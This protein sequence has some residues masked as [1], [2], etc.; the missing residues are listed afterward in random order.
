MTEN[1]TL[2][3]TLPFFFILL[4]LIYSCSDS[5]KRDKS[6]VT[7]HKD[8]IL[9]TQTEDSYSNGHLHGSSLKTNIKQQ[10]EVW[11]NHMFS[12]LDL[13]P[14]NMIDIV[15]N[16]TNFF[17]IIK[18]ST[19][20]LLKEINGIA[21]GSGLD[22]KLV[23]CYNLGEEIYNYRNRPIEQCS[24]LAIEEN[25]KKTLL[26][27]QDL[28]LFL[29][30]NNVP[31]I[32]KSKETIVFTLA[33]MLALSGVSK[34]IAVSCNSL[35]M[36]T[37]NKNGLP[38]SF[39]IREILSQPSSS[40]AFAYIQKTP[41]AIPQNF[42][43]ISSDE[44]VGYEISKNSVKEYRPNG[45]HYLYHTN[46]PLFNIDYRYGDYK[47][48]KCERYNALSSLVGN[49]QEIDKLNITYFTTFFGDSP[50]N[51]R[52]TFLRFSVSFS[53]DQE[54]APT[55]QFINPKQSNTTN[56]LNFNF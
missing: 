52:E 44:M 28:P 4:F 54:G 5:K 17:T 26:Y 31:V 2:S 19:P 30:G 29:H 41:L 7:I 11:Q 34:K 45:K 25:G 24:N 32:L 43:M 3:K 10:I 9:I 21:D 23:L 50:L 42:L 47:K 13:T 55:V 40:S 15:Y 37:M 48:S 39:A 38:L 14:E 12:E 53:T 1:I 16:E 36:L 20:E 8:Y 46:F 6:L 35:P 51:N 56:L 22:R 33:G 49:K 27:N 18:E